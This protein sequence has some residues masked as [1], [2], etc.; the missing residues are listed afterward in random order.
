[1]LVVEDIRRRIAAPTG[2]AMVIATTH[3]VIPM[4]I[5]ARLKGVQ[6]TPA[7]RDN[8]WLAVQPHAIE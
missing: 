7:I 6:E 2:S 5:P 8:L 4:V 1:M 3:N